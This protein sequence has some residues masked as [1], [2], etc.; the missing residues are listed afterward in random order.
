MKA[1][2]AGDVT[3]KK[4]FE[5]FVLKKIHVIAFCSVRNAARF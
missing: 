5:A 3:K 4:G 1:D 2:M